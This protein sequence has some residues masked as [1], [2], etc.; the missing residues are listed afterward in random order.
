M[1]L[2]LP[3]SSPSNPLIPPRVRP[4]SMNTS[5]PPSGPSKMFMVPSNVATDEVQVPLYVP[6][7]SPTQLL[8]EQETSNIEMRRVKRFFI[9]TDYILVK[10]RIP[11]VFDPNN[12]FY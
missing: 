5:G 9:C 3:D 12:Y 7:M 11:F 4:S 8:F 1:F 6:V 10:I 2:Q